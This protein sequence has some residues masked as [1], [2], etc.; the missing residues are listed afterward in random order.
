MSKQ[1]T[2]VQFLIDEMRKRS[3]SVRLMFHNDNEIFDQ[4]K[5]LE[6]QQIEEAWIN[7]SPLVGNYKKNMAEHYYNEKYEQ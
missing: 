1:Q 7:A 6:R 4:A 3:P 5:Q 2:A